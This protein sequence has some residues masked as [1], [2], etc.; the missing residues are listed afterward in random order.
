MYYLKRKLFLQYTETFSWSIF[1]YGLEK[2]VKN[3]FKISQICIWSTLFMS[4]SGVL[5]R[6]RFLKILTSLEIFLSFVN[7]GF[8]SGTTF[9]DPWKENAIENRCSNIKIFFA[10]NKGLMLPV[11]CVIKIFFIQILKNI[12]T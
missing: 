5:F 4:K 10:K 6:P 2:V 7:M 9:K 8:G 12:G 1:S 11:T 3:I